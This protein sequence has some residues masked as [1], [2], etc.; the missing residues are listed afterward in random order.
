MNKPKLT[1]YV[2]RCKCQNLHAK[3]ILNILETV[4]DRI[5]ETLIANIL[6]LKNVIIHLLCIPFKITKLQSPFSRKCQKNIYV[7]ENI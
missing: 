1:N 6:N 2:Q 3:V 4:E 5:L 7:H